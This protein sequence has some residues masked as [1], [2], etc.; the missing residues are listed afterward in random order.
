[1]KKVLILFILSLFINPNLFGKTDKK[2]KYVPIPNKGTKE[3]VEV[4]CPEFND[5]KNNCI[6]DLNTAIEQSFRVTET[7]KEGKYIVYMLKK[8]NKI[9][10]CKVNT[11]DASSWC[12]LVY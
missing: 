4:I 3:W 1:M 2:K 7:F 11:D 5:G 6:D 12:E 10:M 9:A 8:K